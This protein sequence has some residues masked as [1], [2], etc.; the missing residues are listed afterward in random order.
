MSILPKQLIGL[1]PVLQLL[2]GIRHG[3]SDTIDEVLSH[4]FDWNACYSQAKNGSFAQG[5][6]GDLCLSEDQEQHFLDH[7]SS[8]DKKKFYRTTYQKALRAGY[9]PML[10]VHISEILFNE[11]TDEIFKAAVL[12]QKENITHPSGYSWFHVCCQHRPYTH[13]LQTFLPLHGSPVE[14]VDLDGNT[15]FIGFW[16]EII[17]ADSYYGEDL[18]LSDWFIEQGFSPFQCNHRGENVLAL[19]ESCYESHTYEGDIDEVEQYL[20][21]LRSIYQSQNLQVSTP[22]ARFSTQTRRI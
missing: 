2:W 8:D 17:L 5:I 16:K 20:H 1:P 13:A 11:Y 7:L 18:K 4:S 6:L 15:P 9:N 3:S 19:M 21:Q 10:D 22:Q 14:S 12:A